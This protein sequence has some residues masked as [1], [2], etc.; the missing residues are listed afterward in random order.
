MI[1]DA[2]LAEETAAVLRYQHVILNADASEVLVGLEF[3]EVQEFFAVSVGT[4][5]VDELGNE[6]DA[7]L[8]S[9]DISC[10]PSRRST[11]RPSRMCRPTA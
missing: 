8:V 7:R 9:D 10:R 3:V 4:P 11:P 1:R 2:L 5:L 6:V